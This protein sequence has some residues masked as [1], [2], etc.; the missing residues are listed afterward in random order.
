ME[1]SIKL[2][3]Q[4]AQA[5]LQLIDIAIKQLGLNG[6]SAGLALANKIN[7]AFKDE[8]QEKKEVK[9]DDK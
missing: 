3:E 7:Q 1:K 6:A 8:K 9:K 2:N 4:E 5:L